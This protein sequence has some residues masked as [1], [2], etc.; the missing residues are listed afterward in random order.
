MAGCEPQAQP[1]QK[2]SAQTFEQFP[3]SVAFLFDQ[4][5]IQVNLSGV[6]FCPDKVHLAEVFRI[7]LLGT[8]EASDLEVSVMLAVCNER[9]P[10]ERRLNA[11]YRWRRL[12]SRISNK[13]AAEEF[14]DK[15]SH[16]IILVVSICQ[17]S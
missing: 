6:L 13:Q 12:H 1:L 17:M 10:I 9:L 7:L 5:C 15:T 14:A 8:I 11:W 3:V 4:G 16:L 2:P